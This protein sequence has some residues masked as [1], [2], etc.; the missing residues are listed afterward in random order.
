MY[1]FTLNKNDAIQGSGNG[2]RIDTTGK[3]KG[4]VEL[5]HVY[6]TDSGAEFVQINFESDHGQKCRFSICTKGRDGK[7]TFGS[8]RLQAMMACMKLKSLSAVPKVVKDYDYNAGGI[9]DVTRN[10]LQEMM[11]RKIGF[12]LA[13]VYKT[14]EKSG[15]D[16]YEMEIVAP[17]EYETEQTAQEVLEGKPAEGLTRIVTSL[18]DKDQRKTPI[19]AG[20]TGEPGPIANKDF[21]DDIPF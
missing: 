14:N 12:A 2:G 7:E 18:K 9:A 8:K 16:F 20:A 19:Y 17:F 5:A 21:E 1:S 4:K 10:V 6:Q 15:K 13:K 3:Y 11:G